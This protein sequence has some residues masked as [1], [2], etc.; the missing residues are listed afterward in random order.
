MIPAMMKMTGT[1]GFMAGLS[2]AFEII[3]GD[4]LN[5]LLE[6][7]TLERDKNDRI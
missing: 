4:K 7:V 3:Y 1:G 5:N 2:L 6:L